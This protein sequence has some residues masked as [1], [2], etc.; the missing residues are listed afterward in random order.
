MEADNIFNSYYE[1]QWNELISILKEQI[2][3]YAESGDIVRLSRAFSY[4][5]AVSLIYSDDFLISTL[6]KQ[7]NEEYLHAGDDPRIKASY[8]RFLALYSSFTGKPEDAS[9]YYMDA[10][11]SYR[12]TD[13]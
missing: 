5:G 13:W 7:I 2:G 6:F 11:L 10:R 3:C 9:K 12:L 8:A 1:G 4:Y